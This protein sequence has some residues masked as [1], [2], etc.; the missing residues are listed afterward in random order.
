[1]RKENQ[2]RYSI[3]KLFVQMKLYFPNDF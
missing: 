2:L 1:M 3:L